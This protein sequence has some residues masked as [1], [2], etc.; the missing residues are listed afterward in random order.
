MIGRARSQITA[1]AV[2]IGTEAGRRS[3]TRKR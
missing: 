3:S 2:G 1:L